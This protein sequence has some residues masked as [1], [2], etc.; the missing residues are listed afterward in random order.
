[1]NFIEDSFNFRKEIS[2]NKRCPAWR[3]H[4][5]KP[6]KAGYIKYASG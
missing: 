3:K 1:M 4:I 5:M 2:G 6:M